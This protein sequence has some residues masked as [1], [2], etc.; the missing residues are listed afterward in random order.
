MKGLTPDPQPP[1]ELL[2]LKGSTWFVEPN[3]HPTIGSVPTS[4]RHLHFFKGRLI[5]IQYRVDDVAACGRLLSQFKTAYGE[6]KVFA[7]G[8]FQTYDWDGKRESLHF[9]T[10]ARGCGGTFSDSTIGLDAYSSGDES[11]TASSGGG[12]S[13]RALDH[14]GIA[15]LGAD[16]STFAGLKERDRVGGQLWLTMKETT[17]KGVPLGKGTYKFV[18]DKLV[19]VGFEGAKFADCPGLLAA[20][21]SEFG[22]PGDEQ[23]NF[24]GG[25]SYDWQASSSFLTFNMFSS[26]CG[27]ILSTK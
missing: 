24:G 11:N 23:G 18:G 22:P 3:T 4:Q 12:G 1:V 14:F 7:G 19:N 17:F 2:R 16:R 25:K 15:K 10:L 13:T 8:A 21:K 5:G 27:G 9:A 26:T 20:L 6:P